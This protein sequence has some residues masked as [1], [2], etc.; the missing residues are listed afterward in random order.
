M[1]SKRRNEN[2][3]TQSNK[4]KKN[5]QTAVKKLGYKRMKEIFYL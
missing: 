3:P 5:I 1:Q 2:H 4:D